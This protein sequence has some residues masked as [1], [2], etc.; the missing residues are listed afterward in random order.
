MEIHRW[1]Y[2]EKCRRDS[3]YLKVRSSHDERILSSELETEVRE[4]PFLIKKSGRGKERVANFV[5][6]IGNDK[7]RPLLQ[8]P[9]I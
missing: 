7:K 8:R 5:R 1:G 2:P 9:K 4:A 3:L 6:R